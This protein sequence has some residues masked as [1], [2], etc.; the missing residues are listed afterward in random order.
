[1]D[2]PACNVTLLSTVNGTA[3]CNLY[4]TSSYFPA[5][6]VTSVASLTLQ[7][8]ISGT[9]VATSAISTIK[10]HATPVHTS[11]ASVTM[12]VTAPYRNL[13]PG[14]T[15]L[16]QTLKLPVADNSCHV[17]MHEGID[18]TLAAADTMPSD[19]H[20]A[21]FA[22]ISVVLWS[23]LQVSRMSVVLQ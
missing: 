20:E 18:S 17:V 2:L 6:G 8:R 19:S 13:H 15:S 10:L 21:L 11:P 3:D 12:L 1:M 22:R 7:L 16:M 14:K 5:A 4:V 9:T 23:K